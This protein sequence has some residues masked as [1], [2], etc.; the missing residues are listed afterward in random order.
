MTDAE[1]TAQV[2]DMCCGPRMMWFDKHD[3]RAVFLDR[4]RERHEIQRPMRGTVEYTETAPDLMADFTD[5]PFSDESFLHVVFDPPHFERSGKIGYLAKKYGW[6]DG[7]W[8]SMIRAGFAEG[9]RVL[10]PG[11]TLVFKWTA[12]ENPVSEILKLTPHRPLYGHRSGKQSMTHW[13]AFLKPFPVA[14]VLGGVELPL[15][16]FNAALEVVK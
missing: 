15:A 4:R 3:A 12:T 1:T 14:A 7:D 13:M 6:L 2:L 9:F 10:K 11:G 16:L 5:L 8:R